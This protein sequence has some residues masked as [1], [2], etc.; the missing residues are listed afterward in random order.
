MPAWVTRAIQKHVSMK[1]ASDRTS[2]TCMLMGQGAHL[3]LAIDDEVLP[4][5]GCGHW[6]EVQVP[7]LVELE[8]EA[9]WADEAHLQRL[10]LHGPRAG[11]IRLGPWHS[12]RASVQG[13]GPTSEAF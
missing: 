4:Q 8:V 11:L 10:H 7:V 2:Y 12:L 3:E 13:S 6:R 9:L 1:A 5:R